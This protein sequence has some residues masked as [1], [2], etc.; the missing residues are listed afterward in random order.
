M[1]QRGEVDS[2]LKTVA[3][4]DG[5]IVN[6][7]EEKFWGGYGAYFA[8]PVGHLWEIAWNPGFPLDESGSLTIPD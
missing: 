5:S 1:R 8:D 7:P 3:R 4:L 2:I 6:A